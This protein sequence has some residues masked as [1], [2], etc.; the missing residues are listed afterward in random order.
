M[1]NLLVSQHTMPMQ[2]KILYD[3]PN[4]KIEESLVLSALDQLGTEPYDVTIVGAGV[5]GCAIAYNLSQYQLRVLLVDKRYDVGEGTSKGNSAIIATGFDATPG[6]L[7]S[8][9]VT[10]ASRKWPEMAHK[11][12]I[13]FEQSGALLLAIDDEQEGKLEKIHEEALANGVDDVRLVDAAEAKRLEPNASSKVRGG[14]LIPRESIA[15]PFTTPVAYAEVAM[16]NGVDILLGVHIVGLQKCKSTVKNLLTES[17][18]RIATRLIVNAAG[19]GGRDLADLYHGAPFD[20]NPRR[21]QFL[22]FDK[23]CHSIV[24]RILVPLPTAETKGVL[25]IPT[26]FG[27][28]LAGPTAE[29]L[30]L[31]SPEAT[32]T[33]A[34]GL[35]WMLSNASGLCPCLLKQPVIGTYAGERCNC[36]QGSYLIRYNDGYPGILTIAGIRSTGF[37]SSIT[38]AEYVTEGLGEQ[39]DLSLDRDPDAV[40]SRPDSCWPGW[41]RKPID[42]AELVKKNPDYADMV[43]FCEQISR[44]EIIDALDSMLKPRTLD[45]LKRR[46]RV[47]MGRCQGFECRIRVAKIVS[48]HC[49]IPLDNITQKGPGSELVAPA[50]EAIYG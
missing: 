1:S 18:H 50:H 19:L 5:V 49:D 30:P 7:E 8:Q 3:W 16:A 9:L 40:D 15:D 12:K 39:C 47:S 17:G 11:L 10:Q 20:I 13:P 2:G 31:G 24:R 36:K 33:T 35:R 48:E 23:S 4:A 25:V 26:I 32:S 21:G 6:S 27:N 44:G 46:T 37:T 42:D 43:C 34:E 45:A 22:I 28:L 29:D 14:L 41:W 38:L